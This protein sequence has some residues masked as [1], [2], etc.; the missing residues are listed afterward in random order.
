MDELTFKCYQCHHGSPFKITVENRGEVARLTSEGASL[1]KVN[2]ICIHCGYANL[3]EITL[4]T[5]TELI[6]RLSEN[7]EVRDAVDRARKGDYSKA[8]DIANKLGFKF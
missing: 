7:P 5:A 8:L 6:S 2:F 1:G 4:E 3:I